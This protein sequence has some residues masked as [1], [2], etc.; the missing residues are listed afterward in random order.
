[1]S[2]VMNTADTATAWCVHGMVKGTC[3]ICRRKR[4]GRRAMRGFEARYGG[5]CQ[6]CQEDFDVGEEIT[7]VED[8]YVHLECAEAA[9]EVE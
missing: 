7:R 1:M 8:E 3:T 5:R 4:Q 9:L 2:E 6:I